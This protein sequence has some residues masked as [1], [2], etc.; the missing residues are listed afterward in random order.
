MKKVV[1]VNIG[2]VAKTAATLVDGVIKYEWL[3]PLLTDFL[4]PNSG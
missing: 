2:S 4:T 1:S 3:Y